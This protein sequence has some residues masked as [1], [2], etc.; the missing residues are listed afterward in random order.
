MAEGG[1]GRG[2]IRDL[3]LGLVEE[4]VRYVKGGKICGSDPHA[5]LRKSGTTSEAMYDVTQL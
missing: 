5:G 3:P 4:I 2:W 1:G